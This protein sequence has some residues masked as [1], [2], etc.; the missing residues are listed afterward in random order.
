M[1]NEGYTLVDAGVHYDF[2]G[3]LDGVRL[4]FNARNLF[5][6]RY[7]NCQ[8]GYCYRGEARSLVT[9]LSYRW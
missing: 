6:K 3:G 7:V 5:D 9:S 4:A 8:Q 1:K 2:G